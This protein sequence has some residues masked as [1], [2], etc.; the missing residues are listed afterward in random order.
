[1]KF[2]SL[3]FIIILFIQSISC[4]PL[5][6]TV[7]MVKNEAGSIE[8]TL[9]PYIDGGV[10]HFVVFDTGSTDGTQDIA[11]S[12]F[13]KYDISEGHVVEEPFIDFSTSRN[14]ALDAVEGI[15]PDATFM[16][17]PDAEWY[18][19]NVEELLEFCKT[20]KHSNEGSYLVSIKNSA[21][22]FYTSRLIRCK[23]GVKFVGAVHEALNQV[24]VIKA[25]DS[26]YFEWRP[27]QVGKEKSAQRWHRDL[28]L[29]LKSYIEDRRDPRTLFYLAQTYEAL[30]DL[31]NAFLFY[32]K[33][34]EIQG[35]DEENYVTTYR[36]ARVAEMMESK[37]EPEI[38]SD[39]VKLY[40]KAFTMRPHRAEPLIKIAQYYRHKNNMPLAF[41]FA[42][43]AVK[44]PYP[45]QDVLFVEKYMYDF[46]R[47]DILGI[48]S[49]YIGEYET[50]EWAV[51]K[52]LEVNPRAQHLHFNLR[53]YI[54]R[55]MTQKDP[56]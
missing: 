8:E 28:Q 50:G 44:I 5:L 48:C 37:D 16:L 52:A 34:S 54:E 49:W 45:V 13:K 29:L 19:H 11:Q 51:L 6:V 9:Q 41:I 32:K 27:S 39:A 26:A 33:R 22:S 2:K 43:R 55:K 47:Y 40:L 15:F 18:M 1:M 56:L 53:L 46:E 30:D 20:V 21:V 10:K 24:S 35:W 31:E 25:P 4:D 42:S 14:H 38:V 12:L 7:L 17:M 23:C 36:L 3:F